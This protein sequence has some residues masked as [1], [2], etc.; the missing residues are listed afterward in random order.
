MIDVVGDL[1][2]YLITQSSVTNLLD[3]YAGSPAIF[4]GSVPPDHEIGLPIIVIDYPSVQDRKHTSSTI[5]REIQTGIRIYA[6]VS[7]TRAGAGFHDTLPLQQASEAIAEAMITAQ[8]PVSG[9]KLRGAKITGP[10]NAPT[11]S[12]SLAGRLIKLRWNIE[13][14]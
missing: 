8:I 14:N 12:T 5:N 7:F 4:A 1:Y 10:V 13:E 3:S 9:G 2:Q 11:E 6:Q